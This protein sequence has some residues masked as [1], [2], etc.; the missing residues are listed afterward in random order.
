MNGHAKPLTVSEIAAME[1]GDIDLSEIPELGE[2]FRREAEWVGPDRT[3]RI[4]RVLEDHVRAKRGA[5]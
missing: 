2:T 5:R 4:N 1:D 3:E